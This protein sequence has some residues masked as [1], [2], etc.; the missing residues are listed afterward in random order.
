[1]RASFFLAQKAVCF[2]DLEKHVEGT[3]KPELQHSR[4][5]AAW[6]KAQGL[7]TDVGAA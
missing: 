7:G 3:E 6:D 2:E 4:L 5:W 1:M